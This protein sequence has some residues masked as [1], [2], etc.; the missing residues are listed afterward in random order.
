VRFVDREKAKGTTIIGKN[1]SSSITA[2]PR[3]RSAIAT[4]ELSGCTVIIIDYDDV[5]GEQRYAVMG[6]F[7]R[8]FIEDGNYRQPFI[9]QLD[10]LTDRR[11]NPRVV[12]A[13]AGIKDSRVP[14]GYIYDADIE[15]RIISIKE[16]LHARLGEAVPI[17]TIW[18]PPLTDRGNTDSGT[19]LLEYP[20]DETPKPNLIV[21]VKPVDFDGLFEK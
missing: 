4:S 15:D 5:R 7:V 16:L 12:I 10:E 6:H 9:D 17:A 8:F 20:P 11:M 19:I 14:N 2:R 21:W 3:K 1:E 18:Y 13:N